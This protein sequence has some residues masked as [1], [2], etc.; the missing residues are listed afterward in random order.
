MAVNIAPS[1][2]WLNNCFDQAD[3]R[4]H[5]STYLIEG[6]AG[7]VLID[8]GANIHEKAIKEQTRELVGEDG[9]DTIVLTH[10]TLEHTANVKDFETHWGGVETI[11]STTAPEV[12]GTPTAS[13]WKLGQTTRIGGDEFTFLE[14]LL[15][16]NVF[17]VWVYHQPSGTLFTSEAFGRYHTESMCNETPLAIGEDLEAFQNVFKYCADRLAFL[18]FVE[19]NKIERDVR[20]LVTE[21]DVQLLAPAHGNPLAVENL[22]AY[23]ALL[24]NVST[25][26]AY[27]DSRTVQVEYDGDS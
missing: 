15:T 8:T 6:T 21:H 25:A 2:H 17:T 13:A 16:D 22:D 7:T 19:T 18:K 14:P 11:A 26:L 5:L 27:S 20:K 23:F 9:P 4:M 24:A 3:R 1:V 10:S 12:M